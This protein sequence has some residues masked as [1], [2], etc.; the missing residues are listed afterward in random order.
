MWVG[1]GRCGA[2]MATPFPPAISDGEEG[3]GRG[4]WEWLREVDW[5]GRG[6][7]D[8]AGSVRWVGEAVSD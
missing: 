7:L 2:L 8:G 5:D 1:G 6:G 3:S 4:E